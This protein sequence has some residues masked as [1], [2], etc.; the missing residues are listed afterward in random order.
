MRFVEAIKMHF[1]RLDVGVANLLNN[2][3][4][5]LNTHAV[6]KAS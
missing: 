1:Y 5:C 2:V 3:P 6:S 4:K